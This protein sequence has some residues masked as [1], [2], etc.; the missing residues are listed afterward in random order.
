M[1]GLLTSLP[2]IRD[3]H[4]IKRLQCVNTVE[5]GVFCCIFY[6]SGDVELSF[7]LA[8]SD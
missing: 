7:N 3:L 8:K 5:R 1:T 2:V 4:K 6:V